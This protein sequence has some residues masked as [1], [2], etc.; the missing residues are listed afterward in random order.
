MTPTILSYLLA[1]SMLAGTL[2][3][4]CFNGLEKRNGY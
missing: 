3:F 1:T 4:V 2:A